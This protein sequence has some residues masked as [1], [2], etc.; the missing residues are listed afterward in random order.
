MD[1]KELGDLFKEYLNE[2]IHNGWDGFT[3]RDVTGIR[4]MLVDVVTYKENRN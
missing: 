2:S 3:T 4:R 1:S